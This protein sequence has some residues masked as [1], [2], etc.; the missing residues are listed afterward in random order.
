MRTG[1]A[2]AYTSVSEPVRVL[3]PTAS[4]SGA[5]AR[6]VHALAVT[7]VLKFSVRAGG[8]F[9]EARSRPV[10]TFVSVS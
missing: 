4:G 2:R 1:S 3:S 8:A 5:D 7:Q 10:N 6:C 9:G